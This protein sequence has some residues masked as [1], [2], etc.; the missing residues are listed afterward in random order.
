MVLAA[1]VALASAQTDA[2]KCA[3]LCTFGPDEDRSACWVLGAVPTNLGNDLIYWKS[4]PQTCLDAIKIAANALPLSQLKGIFPTTD[5]ANGNANSYVNF[6][7]NGDTTVAKGLKIGWPTFFNG[8]GTLK[9][10][11]T[12]MGTVTDCKTNSTGCYN[13]FKS[14]LTTDAAAK[15]QMQQDG[16]TLWNTFRKDRELEQ[17][18]ARINI[19]AAAIGSEKND[20]DRQTQIASC[21]D[22]KA[23]IV[24]L[25]TSLLK[26]A[27]TN[28]AV[29]CSSYGI[30]P[31][32]RTCSGSG[33]DPI[34]T[35][36]VA[37]GSA[38]GSTAGG[39]GTTAG[40][41]DRGLGGNA[42]TVGISAMAVLIAGA[43]Q[44]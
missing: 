19:C 15:T 18:T 6:L 34:V 4:A 12:V 8:D 37:G 32:T 5:G 30:G 16:K 25:S 20:A 22:L 27:Q 28:G 10:S 11:I 9:D 43:A 21:P 31:G 41:V 7:K 3:K 29:Q 39:N 13:V 26:N 33:S 35:T 23:Q 38:A 17:A 40:N 24:E 2:E 42:V 14:F 1:M 36:T 44:L